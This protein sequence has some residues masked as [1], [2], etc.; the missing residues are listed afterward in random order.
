VRVG[1]GEGVKD[2]ASVDVALGVRVGILLDV[3][4]ALGTGVGWLGWRGR[5]R[6]TGNGCWSAGEQ[7]RLGWRGQGGGDEQ[8]GQRDRSPDPPG[9]FVPKRNPA[10]AH[11]RSCFVS[12]RVYTGQAHG[13][14]ASACGGAFQFWGKFQKTAIGADLALATSILSVRPISRRGLTPRACRR[15]RFWT[16]NDLFET[17]HASTSSA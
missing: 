14:N 15:M 16:K 13:S 10:S 9:N 3:G 8:R 7:G 1:R 4:V 17:R 2:G 6:G 5:R 11:R 12:V